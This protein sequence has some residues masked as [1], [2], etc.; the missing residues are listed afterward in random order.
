[1]YTIHMYAVMMRT[2]KNFA[3]KKYRNKR[4]KERKTKMMEKNKIC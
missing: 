3:E 4:N 2:R 1:M